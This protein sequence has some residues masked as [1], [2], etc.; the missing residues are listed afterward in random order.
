[1]NNSYNFEGF[2]RVNLILKMDKELKHMNEI[3]KTWK[4]RES[5]GKG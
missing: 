2:L 3:Q 4:C 5:K 1:M